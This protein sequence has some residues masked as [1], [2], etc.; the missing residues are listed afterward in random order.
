MPAPTKLF[1]PS[2]QTLLGLS[3]SNYTPLSDCLFSPRNTL[4]KRHALLH[5][6]IALNIDK[7]RAWQTML[8]NE[9]GLLVPLNV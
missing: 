9:D 5:E 6:L 3:V 2:G 8:G 7:V 4:Q 1:Q